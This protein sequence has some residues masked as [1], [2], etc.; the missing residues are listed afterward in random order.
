ML[1]FHLSSQRGRK[2][3]WKEPIH[4]TIHSGAGHRGGPC[5]VLFAATV[6]S[7]ESFGE[8]NHLTDH[9]CWS[10]RSRGFKPWISSSAGW[11]E[12]ENGGYWGVTGRRKSYNR[13]QLLCTSLS[14]KYFLLLLLFLTRLPLLGLRVVCSQHRHAS[15]PLGWSAAPLAFP[16]RCFSFSF[17]YVSYVPWALLQFSLYTL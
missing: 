1:S 13:W 4:R 17:S 14:L 12:S 9:G 6:D 11:T 2:H 5:W 8:L 10:L 16:P 15:E 7:N 3:D